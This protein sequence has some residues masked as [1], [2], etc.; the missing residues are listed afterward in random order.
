MRS[1]TSC[2][3]SSS[4]TKKPA[5]SVSDSQTKGS[6]V[7]NQYHQQRTKIGSPFSFL[8][9]LIP[10]EQKVGKKKL[11]FQIYTADRQTDE[12]HRLGTLKK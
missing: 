9:F 1:L 4:D 6:V 8:L 10:I 11:Y 2:N 3:R 12:Q 7:R 5:K